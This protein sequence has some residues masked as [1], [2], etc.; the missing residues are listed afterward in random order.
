M[1]P[2]EKIRAIRK[3]LRKGIP[4]GELKNQLRLEGFSEDDIEKVFSPHVP[5]M[6]SWLLFFAIV[7]FLVAAYLFVSHRGL[8]WLLFILSGFLF[9]E[10]YQLQ[11]KWNRKQ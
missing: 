7:I 9:Y 1:L 6:R 5:D 11:K 2:D 10:Y 4:E 8:P 3:N